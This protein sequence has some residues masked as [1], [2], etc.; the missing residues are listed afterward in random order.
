MLAARQPD[1]AT[2]REHLQSAAAQGQVDEL[3]VAEPLPAAARPLWRVFMSIAGQRRSGG[4]GPS[5][6]TFTDVEAYQRLYGV[7]FTPWELDTL[8]AIDAASL[9]AW[10]KQ[11]G[12]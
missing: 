6:L 9:G 10:M 8:F 3:L 5:S 4:M 12:S 7:Q 2:L 11:K 1:G